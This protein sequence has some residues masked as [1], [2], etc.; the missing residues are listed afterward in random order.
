MNNPVYLGLSI[1]V[2]L[3]TVMHEFRYDYVKLKYS[4]KAKLCYM[5]P[6]SFICHLKR[7]D[8]YSDIAEDFKTTLDTWNLN[9]TDHY[10]K[11]N[12]RKLL[13]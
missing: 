13:L 12:A 11:E 6:C 7:D 8:I 3:K 4:E 2:L 9:L 5:D 10:Q 1:L